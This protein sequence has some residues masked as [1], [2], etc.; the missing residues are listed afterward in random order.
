MKTPLSVLDDFPTSHSQLQ[1][2]ERAAAKAVM[3]MSDS[4][5]KELAK[6]ISFAFTLGVAVG[7]AFVGLFL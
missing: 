3:A 5:A 2:R 1:E 6:A 4:H 7:A